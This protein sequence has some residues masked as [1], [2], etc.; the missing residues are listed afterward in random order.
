VRLARVLGVG[1]GEVRLHR[2]ATDEQRL[3]DQPLVHGGLGQAA[4][5]CDDPCRTQAATPIRT[6]SRKGRGGLPGL[7]RGLFGPRQV[8]G[9]GLA[10]GLVLVYDRLRERG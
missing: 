2:A 4:P 10:E 7:D 8:T 6:K 3:V 9:V 5:Q 1:A